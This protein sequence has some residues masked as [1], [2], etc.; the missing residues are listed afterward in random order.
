MDDYVLIGKE[1]IRIRDLPHGPDDDCQFFAVG[2]QRVGYLGTT[3]T[4]QRS[5]R[6][7][8]KVTIHPPG[9]TFPPNGL[10]VVTLFYRNDDGG[11]GYG[12]DSRLFFDPPADGEYRVRVG[13]S[14][15]QGSPRHAYRLTV[16]PPR[17]DFGVS[18]SPQRPAGVARRG[19][20]DRRDGVADRR[21]RR[22]DR[23]AARQPAAGLHAGPSRIDADQM[24]TAFA[25]LA[26][27]DR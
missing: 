18:F 23:R 22:A 6:P 5:A 15:G 10:P 9:T 4:Q 20:A 11:P 24:S 14:R 16:R 3:P 17:P 8:Y 2:G 21:V 27:A 1:L 26:D 12:K 19:R 25:L 13:D 7:M